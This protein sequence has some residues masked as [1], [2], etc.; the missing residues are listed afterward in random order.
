MADKRARGQLLTRAEK[1]ALEAKREAQQREEERGRREIAHEQYA[2]WRENAIV[3]GREA[4]REATRQAAAGRARAEAVRTQR[5]AE[6]R[7]KFK[8]WLAE[9]DARRENVRAEQLAQEE[10]ALLFMAKRRQQN[11]DELAKW[12]QDARGRAQTKRD[13]TAAE[14]RT[15]REMEVVDTKRSETAQASFSAW[16]EAKRA[17]ASRAKARQRRKEARV[18]QAAD[19]LVHPAMSAEIAFYSWN[20]RKT[21][22][23]GE[24]CLD[25]TVAQL[26]DTVASEDLLLYTNR[27]NTSAQLPAIPSNRAWV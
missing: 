22:Y 1:R 16:A 14:L 2:S 6:A 8:R 21:V 27:G 11:E 15:Q 13:R 17:E 12:E 9:K 3:L 20:S 10:R 24:Y 7:A 26:P 4:A 23:G 18:L 25:G 5:A 19:G